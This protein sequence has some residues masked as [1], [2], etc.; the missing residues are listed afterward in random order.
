MKGT[1]KWYD[2]TKGF[3]II[4]TEEGNELFVHYSS[5]PDEEFAILEEGEDVSFNV[6]EG[7]RGP[8]AIEVVREDV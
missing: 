8:H 6:A 7:R 4:Q 1:V 5:I 3:G 2:P